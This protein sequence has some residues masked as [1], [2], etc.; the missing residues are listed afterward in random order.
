MGL[1]FPFFNVFFQEE[2]HASTSAIGIIFF[3]SL[4]LGLPCTLSAPGMLR[5]F[6]ATFTLVPLRAIGA[7]ALSILGFWLNLP[8]AVLLFLIST[9]LESLTTPAEM[10]FATNTLPRSYWGR[11]QSLRV[12]GFQCLSALG[13][14][15]AGI[16]I[17][18]YGYS[19]AFF[20][21]G[22]ARMTS[23]FIFLVI[24]G[25]KKKTQ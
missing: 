8:F 11:M 3:L 21:A 20:L 4:A 22:L 1:S 23:A 6:G 14:V 17:V 7:I 12:T 15:A 24:F 5:R 2:L 18:T 19:V 10:A 25:Y 16:L 9:A 13:S